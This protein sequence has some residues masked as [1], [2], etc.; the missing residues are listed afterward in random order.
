M[1]LMNFVA[2]ITFLGAIGII[3]RIFDV[4]IPRLILCSIDTVS[5]GYYDSRVDKLV[6]CIEYLE[7]VTR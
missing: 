6:N 3:E 7:T 2:C 5:T 4:L 1:I